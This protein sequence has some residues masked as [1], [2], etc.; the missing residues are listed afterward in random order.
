MSIVQIVFS[1]K[2]VFAL[3]V[4]A[5]F[6]VIALLCFNRIHMALEHSILQ[7]PWDNIGM[8]LLRAALILVFILLAYPI[9]FGM[10]DAPSIATLIDTSEGRINYLINILFLITLLFPLVPLLGKWEELILPAQ[11]IAACALLF[12]WITPGLEP[13]SIHYWPG[14]GTLLLI[15]VLAFITHW[16]AQILSHYLGEVMDEN[17]NVEQSGLLLSRALVLFMQS[18]AI[19]LFSVALGRQIG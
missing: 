11:A 2:F 18:P 10:E 3:G 12:S 14:L 13:G 19:L 16:L 8:P 15:L 4:Y 5:V 17:F 6:I 1:A 7:W 9:I